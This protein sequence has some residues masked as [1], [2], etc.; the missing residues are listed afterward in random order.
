MYCV[1]T[2]VHIWKCSFTK[3]LDDIAVKNEF[4][5][6]T[7]PWKEFRVLKNDTSHFTWNGFKKFA[8]ALVNVLYNMNIRNVHIISDSTI[9][10]WN[11]ENDDTRSERANLFLEKIANNHNINCSIDAHCGSG[12][13]AMKDVKQ[14]FRTRLLKYELNNVNT[15]DQHVTLFIGGWNDEPYNKNSINKQMQRI[16]TINMKKNTT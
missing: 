6:I 9:D 1:K 16:K 5:L 15:T 8:K 4:K 2:N 3:S 12:F 11:W 10:F 14:D 7:L 13:V